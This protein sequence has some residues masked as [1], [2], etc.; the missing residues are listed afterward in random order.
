MSALEEFLTL[1]NVEDI[2]QDVEVKIGG[3]SY[4]FTVRALTNAEHNEF[5]KRAFSVNS[6]GKI[7]FDSGKYK[8]LEVLHC[9]VSP[10]FSDAEFLKKTGCVS[11]E[12]FY[13]KHVPAGV[14]QHIGSKIEELSGFTPFDEEVDEAKN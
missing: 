4:T 3:K 7:A 10:D 14:V 8:M 1:G 13:T 2:R 9:V 12:D 6:K 5:Q 11:A